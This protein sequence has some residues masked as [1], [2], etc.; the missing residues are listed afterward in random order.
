MAC[1]TL[2]GKR[3]PYN[4]LVCKPEINRPLRRPRRNFE[5][6]IKLDPKEIRCE[7]MDWIHVVQDGFISGLL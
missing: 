7:F 3:N 2:W 6:N 4:I 1:I 5:D